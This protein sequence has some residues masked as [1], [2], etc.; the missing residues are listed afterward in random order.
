MESSTYKKQYRALMESLRRR[1]YSNAGKIARMLLE[2]FLV[3]NGNFKASFAV[4]IGACKDGCFKALR[5]K[6]VEDGIISYDGIKGKNW[7]QYYE[8]PIL[9]RYLNPIRMT[10]YPLIT[11]PEIDHLSETSRV[12]GIL[13]EQKAD[14]NELQDL[15]AEMHAMKEKIDQITK[16]LSLASEPPDSEKKQQT[17]KQCIEELKRINH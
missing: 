13:I 9:S 11:R 2:G 3:H 17:R 5:D 14:R 6:L 8:T 7:T 10:D 16:N 4:E 1:K 12:H 15:R